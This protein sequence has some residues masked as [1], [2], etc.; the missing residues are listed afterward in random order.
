MNFGRSTGDA[1]S[2]DIQEQGEAVPKYK[3]VNKVDMERL[4]KYFDGLSNSGK[5]RQCTDQ[6]SKLINKNN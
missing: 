4:Q 3:K 2:I 5:R 1:V 6:I